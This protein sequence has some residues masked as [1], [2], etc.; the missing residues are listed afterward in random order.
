MGELDQVERQLGLEANRRR[1][2]R[3][4]SNTEATKAFLEHAERE[5]KAEAARKAA[6]ADSERL[7]KAE[8]KALQALVDDVVKFHDALV[9]QIETLGLSEAA[10]LKRQA[11]L[12]GLGDTEDANIDALVR[13]KLALQDRLAVEQSM[14][15][16]ATAMWQQYGQAQ[17]TA[18]NTADGA[19]EAWANGNASLTQQIR[20]LGLT[21]EAVELLAAANQYESDQ[22]KGLLIEDTQAREN[23]LKAL[24]KQ[25]EER[26]GLIQS[27]A[28]AQAYLSLTATGKKAY[29][30]MA[31]AAEESFRKITDSL[32]D[33]LVSAWEQGK[34]S[35]ET[36]IDW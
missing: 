18:I 13:G 9:D 10:I 27:G 31:K 7:Y 26:V 32:T 6:A 19:L 36:F 21:K 23:Y 29:E 20:T 1:V 22:L 15:A 8:Q 17:Q 5:R 24:R 33:A 3:A 14:L 30:D 11:R 12:K 4:N 35:T 34:L 2:D 16:A 25:Y 28:E